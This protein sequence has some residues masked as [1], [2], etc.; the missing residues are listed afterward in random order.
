M[1]PFVK[2]ADPRSYVACPWDLSADAE[3]RAWWVPYFKKHYLTILK[4]GVETAVRRGADPAE[5]QG[6][7]D[8]CRDSFWKQCDEFLARPGEFGRVDILILDAWRDRRL[9]QFG[10]LDPFIDVKE[11]EN[12]R[13]L[14]LLPAVVRQLDALAGCEQ[15]KAVLEGVFAGN[16]FDLGS[17][18]TTA[19]FLDGGPD[20][21][22]VRSMLKPRPWLIDDCDALLARLVDGPPYR[23]MVYFID[24]AGSDFLLGAL[25]MMRWM[26]KRGTHIVLAAN[27]KPTLNDM[28]IHDVRRWWPKVLEVEP[29]FRGLPIEPVS[30]GTAE[31]LLDLLSVSDELNA[32]AED[33]DLVLIE[34]MGRGIE[35][36]LDAQL[37]CDRI[38]LA[39]VKMAIVARHLGG[40]VYDLVCRFARHS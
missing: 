26:A 4:L 15:A 11:R 10:F 36:N 35:T 13:M 37:T 7:A 6:R 30:T 18:A 25:P 20:F 27:E 34:G 5:A 23:K 3:D 28:T 9:E 17:D 24:N 12:A 31:P 29:S 40:E 19:R 16:I 39:M 2:L 8:A 14:P 22:A 32:A 33:A 21:F 1:S 38:N